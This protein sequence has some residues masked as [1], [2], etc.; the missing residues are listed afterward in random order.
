MFPHRYY[1]K[2]LLSRAVVVAQLVVWSLL[3]PEI[4]GSNPVIGELNEKR[5][6]EV[7]NDNSA[8]AIFY[9]NRIKKN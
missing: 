3:T 9:Q 5:K 4:R 1:F 7:G 8:L 6:K 2:H